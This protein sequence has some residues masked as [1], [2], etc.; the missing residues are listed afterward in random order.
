MKKV[1]LS[2]LVMGLVLSLAGCDGQ[3]PPPASP[4]PAAEPRPLTQAEIDRV[5]EAFSP[6]AER[7][8]VVYTTPVNGFFTNYYDDVKNLD[9]AD[10]LYYFPDDGLVEN[11]D[12]AEFDALAAL[13]DIPWQ[14]EINTL[15]WTSPADLPVP[16]HRILRSSVDEALERYAGIT[17][18]DLTNT[19]GTLYLAEYDA[20]Y[21]FTSDFGPGMF[22]CAGGQVDETAGTALLWTD[23]REDGSRTELTLARDGEDWHIRSHRNTAD[24]ALLELLAGLEGED[25]GS[26]SWYGP[27]DPP[28]AEKLAALIRAAAA[29]PVDHPELTVNGSDTDVVWSLDC[30]LAP[31]DQ[32]GCSGEDAL[33]L[34]A[35]LEEN[36]VEVFGGS[37]LP[38]GTVHLEDETLYQLIRT[39]CDTP[40]DID[41]EACAACRELTDAYYDARLAQVSEGGFVSWE[42]TRFREEGQ[43]PALDAKAYAIGAA[44][45]TDPPER[46]PQL[47]AG[48]AYVDS[49]LRVI[50][51]DWQATY[52]VTIGGQPAGVLRLGEP[53]D[54]GPLDGFDSVAA[55]RAALWTPGAEL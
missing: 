46:A 22:V 15:G 32:E 34:W 43:A 50:G 36:V 6:Q 24:D 39:S 11:T 21:T 33:N 29:H 19:E 17:S 53:T 51:L 5:N 38:Q 40:D 7:D 3:T 23:T 4:S 47:L 44:F 27:N 54:N 31:K 25:I 8:G 12:Q 13:P 42:L 30:Y 2:L 35:G 14:E 28:E 52:L 18:T 45:R 26:V 41:R 20:W 49:R 1:L 37:S 55:L 48:G 9:F 10:F 16:V